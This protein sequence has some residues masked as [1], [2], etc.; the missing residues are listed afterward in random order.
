[1]SRPA[2]SR[3]I[4]RCDWQ[5][6]S[7]AGRLNVERRRATRRTVTSDEPL[8][9]AKLRT[10]GQLV[11][12]DASNWG[13]LTE[14]PERLLPGRHLDVHI[15]TPAGR[16]LVRSRVA[17]AYVCRVQPDAIHYHAALTFDH[18]IDASACG[19]TL[20]SVL[21]VSPGTPGAPHVAQNHNA[22]IVFDERVTA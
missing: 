16:T 17:R 19:Y 6:F 9:H 7:T 12:L 3:S 5:S 18:S 14:T 20:P 1:L 13:A 10:G 2:Q 8:A 21:A 22:D 15:V 4:I 11:V